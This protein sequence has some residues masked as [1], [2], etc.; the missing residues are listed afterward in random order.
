MDM[1][2]FLLT[3]FLNGLLAGGLLLFFYVIFDRFLTPDRKFEDVFFTKGVSGGAIVVAAFIIGL[4]LVLS[5]AA[6]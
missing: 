5:R 4:S 6:F 1:T 2:S 3:N